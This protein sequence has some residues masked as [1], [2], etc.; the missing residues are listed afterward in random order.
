MVLEQCIGNL[1]SFNVK[2]RLV[3]TVNIEWF[4]LDKKL[5]RKK[6]SSGEEIGIRIQTHLH[7]GDVLYA[8]ETRVIAIDVLPCELVAVS[9]ELMT[10]M[11]RLCFELGNRHLSLAI[12]EHCVT[13]PYDEPT[14]LYLKKLGFHAEKV[15]D[16]FT[17]FTV[18]HAH[19][20]S[21][22]EEHA[23][24]H[25]HEHTHDQEPHHDHN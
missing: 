10:E 8:D 9:V 14:Y 2:D 18:C 25:S 20:H 23:H 19:G 3:D 22:G 5:L 1:E 21:H 4:E 11:G 13:I 7:D 12:E 17:H 24:E 6:T 16:K 15:V